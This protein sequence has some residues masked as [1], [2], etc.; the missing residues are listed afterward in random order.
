MLIIGNIYKHKGKVVYDTMR[1]HSKS[2]AAPSRSKESRQDRSQRTQRQGLPEGDS[3]RNPPTTQA[4][5]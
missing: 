5:Q 1:K 3:D 2:N 4:E